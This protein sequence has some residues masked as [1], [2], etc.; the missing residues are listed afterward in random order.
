MP[1]ILVPQTQENSQTITFFAI[2]LSSMAIESRV[3]IEHGS[4]PGSLGKPTLYS[5]F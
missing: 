2:R 1:R 3:K 5:Q 4:E